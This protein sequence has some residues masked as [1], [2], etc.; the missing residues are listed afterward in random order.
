VI[1]ATALAPTA[2]EAD[3]LAKAALLSGPD[4]AHKWL[5]RHGGLFITDDGTVIHV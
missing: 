2:T 4:R 3:T 1:G 5:R